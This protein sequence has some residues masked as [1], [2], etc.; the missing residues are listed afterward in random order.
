MSLTTFERLQTSDDALVERLVR[1][2]L[3]APTE[4]EPDALVVLVP[5]GEAFVPRL[6][7]LGLQERGLSVRSVSVQR[8]SLDDVFLAYTGSRLQDR[9][10][11]TGARGWRGGRA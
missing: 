10:A 5:D 4:R 8:P 11:A 1:D 2:E 6:F 7:G 9:Q 3:G